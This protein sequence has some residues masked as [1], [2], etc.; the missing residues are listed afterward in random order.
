VEDLITDEESDAFTAAAKPKLHR[1]N[2]ANG[3][4]GH[5]LSEHRKD[6]QAGVPVP[7]ELESLS[8]PIAKVARRL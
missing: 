6:W 2:V 8:N 1:G 4:D 5:T 7:R 3:S